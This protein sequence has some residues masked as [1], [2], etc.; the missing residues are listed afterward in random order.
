VGRVGELY[1]PTLTFETCG[2]VWP[3]PERGNFLA[4]RLPNI[5]GVIL[6]KRS[7]G[8][9]FLLIHVRWNH[10]ATVN[11]HG[12]GAGEVFE[13]VAIKQNDIGVFASFQ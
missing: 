11:H 12:G 3:Y 13:G 6:G 7:S 10:P 4:Q 8:Q 2:S 1:G 9:E 5:T